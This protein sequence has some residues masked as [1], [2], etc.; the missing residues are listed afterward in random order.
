MGVAAA[1]GFDGF[2]PVVESLLAEHWVT[3]VVEMVSRERTARAVPLA[4]W[5]GLFDSPWMLLV[6]F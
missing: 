5:T 1:V 3:S 2:E 4:V 6:R